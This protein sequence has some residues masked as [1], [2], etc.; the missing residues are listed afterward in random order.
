MKSMLNALRQE[1]EGVILELGSMI[2]GF[3]DV[4]LRNMAVGFVDV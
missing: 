3:M 2:V 4:K 1:G